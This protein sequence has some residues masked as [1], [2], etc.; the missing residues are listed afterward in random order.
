MLKN[1]IYK[2][3]DE[4][5]ES[6]FK[7]AEKT[8]IQLLY[9]FAKLVTMDKGVTSVLFS[10][11]E[12]VELGEISEILEQNGLDVELLKQAA[13]LF[14]G[15]DY[16]EATEALRDQI[17]EY[18][19]SDEWFS[20]VSIVEYI[21]TLELPMLN[22]FSR[23][24][25]IDDVLKYRSSREVTKK[26][27]PPVPKK[28]EETHQEK[29]PEK[30]AETPAKKAEKKNTPDD[31][32][33][34]KREKF[35]ELIKKT[36]GLYSDLKEYVKGQDEAVRVF[37]EGYFQ[38]EVLKNEENDSKGPS[39]T[40]LFAGPPGVGKT[41]LAS[42]TAELLNMPYL[43]LDMSEYSLSGSVHTLSGTPK[44]YSGPKA[45]TLTSFVEKNPRCLVLIDEVEKAHEDVIYQFLQVLDGGTLTDGYTDK[46]VDFKRTM[47]IFTTNVG[48]SLYEARDRGNLS[49]LPKSVVIKAIENETDEYGKPRFPAAIC[50]RFAA[51]NV[52]MF[53]HLGVHN[54]IDIING[55]FR[56]YSGKIMNEYGYEM[57][58]DDVI[59]SVLLYSQ[60]SGMDARNMAAQSVKILKNEIFELGRHVPDLDNSLDR[61]EK[62]TINVD[63]NNAKP[64]I[65]ELFENSSVSEVVYF[66]NSGDISEVPFGQ[67][68]HV[69]TFSDLEEMDNYIFN[70]EV[71][72]VCIDPLFGED[73][74]YKEY[75]SLDD[76]RSLGTKAFEIMIDKYPQLPV[77][78]IEQDEIET[79]DK[80]MFLEKGVRE[81]VKMES[82][83][84]FADNVA[85]ICNMLYLQK[86]IDELSGR[87]RVLS[88]NTEQK[89]VEDGKVA[90][91]SFYDFRIKVATDS[92]ENRMLLS[93]QERPTDRFADVIGAENAKSEL[94]YF[95]EYM[96]NPKQFMAKGIKVPKGILLYGPPGTG[97]TMLARAMAGECDV[98]FIP[99]T[100]AGFS[101]KYIGEGEKKISEVFKTAKKF[102]PSVIFI[103][104]I[105]A[106]GKERT[107]SEHT[108]YT[109]GL[110]NVLL[111]EM[112]GFEV[113][114]S[115]P[116]F[117]VA[118]TNYDIEGKSAGK[119]RVI[120]SALLRRFDNRIYVDLPNEEEREK[121][122][123]V[124]SSKQVNQIS[125]NAVHNV[126]QRTTGE[127]LA[128]LKNVYELCLRNAAKAGREA[129]DEDLLNALEDYM[130]GEKRE[131]DE[132]YYHS[133]AI[134]ESGHAYISHLSGEKPSYV[135]I[136]SRGD[137][138]GYMQ[139][140]NSESTPSYSRENLIWRI[141]VALAGRAAELEF[142]GEE[143][144]TN[145]G[146]SS[147]IQQATSVALNMLC[148]YAMYD[149]Y[150]VS[151]PV[152]EMLK[153]PK[154]DDILNKA[155]NILRQE[156]EETRKL[157]RE[158]RDKIE[159]LSK[160]LMKN[161]QATESEICKCF[162]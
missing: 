159:N 47:L 130:Y 107:G 30:A 148:R 40:F 147:D 51:G 1:S 71:M 67:K 105:D 129:T 128:I 151:L 92:E 81:F 22:V 153:T 73:E 90:E 13:P 54:L 83:V 20:S 133:V 84:E 27:K 122:L 17:N 15:D 114:A 32:N 61:L 66:G 3:A 140:Q 72:F 56:L 77:Y 16:K 141:R 137:F 24:N 126:A 146:V 150:Q 119:T 44:S 25:T 121:Y 80:P 4:F 115:K 53:N 11:E 104:E 76:R 38:S 96:K 93:E 33:K 87:G 98:T 68:C 135:T 63:F 103:D 136:V 99:V 155:E 161:N 57:E 14:T 42:T 117:V 2:Q 95:I 26:E 138:G 145:T 5:A 59:P 48:K 55:K 116:V 109:E 132:A 7:G 21:F 154:G 41:Y 110:L 149:D 118:A 101:D 123:K 36:T 94:R 28:K 31:K 62:I 9:G 12:Q 125:D 139:H 45:G 131:W 23:G 52:V 39:A 74:N 143:A 152:E 113:N 124:L 111:T 64:E 89:I 29:T 88:Y 85:K 106:I 19:S 82:K 100:A 134:H 127:S 120:D 35:Q 6:K 112:D 86:K 8:P 160:Y 70:N 157:V 156:M 102:A 108:H 162:E 65:K 43:R 18:K 69:K 10:K 49:I 97:K 158:G 34:E 50:S 91:I 58:I 142:F 37:V 144:G 78:M 75:L 60:T 79:E 46:S